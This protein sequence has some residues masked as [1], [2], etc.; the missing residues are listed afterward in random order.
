M[1][2]DDNNNS[3]EA[4]EPKC[5]E[6]KAGLPEW[7]ATFSDL[8]TLLLTF[9]V[10]LLSFAK[11]ET[12][13][14]KAAL[15][16]IRKAFGGNV[17][18]QGEVIM[19]G[20][21][22]DDSPTMID[23]QE[24]VKPFPIDFLTT[25]GLLDKHEIN[26]A[27]EEDLEEFKALLQKND[28]AGSADVYEMNEGVKVHMKEKVY[29]EEGEVKVADMNVKDF[30]NMIKLIREN[31]WVIYIQGHA[32]E[33]ETSNEPGSDPYSLSAR[34]AIAVSKFFIKEGV[35]AEKI[36]TVSYGDSRPVVPK[37]KKLTKRELR[38]LNRRVEF[39]IRKRDLTAEGHKVSNY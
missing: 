32:A 37:G 39:V 27:S 14:Y 29:F 26:R 22:P 5:P 21:S 11:T 6:C 36:I 35:K 30:Q 4:V 1:A 38:K 12:N 33:N 15:G 17:H 28:L 16:S 3:G 7:M 8:V 13:K 31:N 25:E 2:D 9:F 20:K 34:R 24:P 19:P 23:S 18:L 10:L